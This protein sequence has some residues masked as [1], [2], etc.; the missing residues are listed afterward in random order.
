M[1]EFHGWAT[2]RF[3]AENCDRTDE[4]ESQAAV[5]AIVS[6]VHQVGYR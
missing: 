1:F 5:V 6:H 4:E 2:I 3:T